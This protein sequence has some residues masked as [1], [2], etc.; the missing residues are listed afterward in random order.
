MKYGITIVLPI[1]NRAHCVVKTLNSIAESRRQPEELLIVDNGSTD[2]SAAVCQEWAAANSGEV[3]HVQVLSEPQPGANRARNLGLAACQTPYVCFFDSDDR[4]DADALTDIHEALTAQPE[5]DLLF[6]PVQQA[7]A[8]GAERVRSYKESLSP[9]VH[10]LNGMM[11]TE[12]M[13]FR[14]EWLRE[15]GGWNEGLTVWQDWELGVRVTLQQPRV[16]WLTNRAYH[17]VLLHAESITG[18]NFT[19]TLTGTLNTMRQALKEVHETEGLTKRERHQA[20]RALYFRARIMAGKLLREHNKE[21]AT[22]YR[23]LSLEC[24][25]HAAKPLKM[26]GFW[27][28]HYVAAGGRGAWRAALALCH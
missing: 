1:R 26:T 10:I 3:F 16:Q 14:T 22:A 15:I 25:P 24:L 8:G 2:H 28:E 9:A 23:Q 27:I 6:L 11:S 7:T 12:S 4:F 20:L 5:T 19:Q 13:V 18:A 21:G 17:H